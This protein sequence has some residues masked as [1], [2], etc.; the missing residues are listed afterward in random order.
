MRVDVLIVEPNAAEAGALTTALRRA[1]APSAT[2]GLDV[3]VVPSS[4]AAQCVGSFDIAIVESSLPDGRGVELVRGW[5]KRR[6]LREATVLIATDA[7]LSSDMSE[8]YL[9]GAATVPKRPAATLVACALETIRRHKR[10]PRSLDEEIATF[11]ASLAA[12]HQAEALPLNPTHIELLQSLLHGRT[13][14]EIGAMRGTSAA[15]V[16]TQVRDL[17]RRLRERGLE[18]GDSL[19]VALMREMLEDRY[20]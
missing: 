10:K 13:H 17:A 19:A 3:T 20:E 16:K 7:P 15:T 14:A 4:A 9:L 12:E 18:V 6:R 1:A 5:R 2:F 8:G 11:V